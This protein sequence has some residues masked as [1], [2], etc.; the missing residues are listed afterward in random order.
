LRGTIQYLANN[1]FPVYAELN[2][3]GLFIARRN[4]DEYMF[5]AANLSTDVLK[6]WTFHAPAITAD[7]FK[8]L[9]G[10]EWQDIE[11]VRQGEKLLANWTLAPFEWLIIRGRRLQDQ[12]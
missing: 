11:V 8:I 1:E 5:A 3:P 2:E 10:S 12:K 4:N 7:R 6:Q 9:T